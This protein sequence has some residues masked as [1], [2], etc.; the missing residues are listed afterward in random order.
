MSRKPS[1]KRRGARK[2]RRG[3][4]VDLSVHEGV[5]QRLERMT[6]DFNA[7]QQRIE[8]LESLLIATVAKAGGVIAVDEVQP[9][10]YLIEIEEAPGGLILILTNS[11]APGGQGGKRDVGRQ[12]NHGPVPADREGDVRPDSRDSRSLS[13]GDEAGA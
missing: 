11:E 9:A 5:A 7:A 3:R 6:V 10:K 4:S 13:T 1:K 2:R 12:N 8:I